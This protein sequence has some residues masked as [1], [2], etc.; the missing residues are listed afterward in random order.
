MCEATAPLPLGGDVGA[1]GGGVQGRALG[2][3]DRERRRK[4]GQTSNKSPNCP[5]GAACWKSQTLKN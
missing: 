1:A 4:A 2:E 3:D 5:G